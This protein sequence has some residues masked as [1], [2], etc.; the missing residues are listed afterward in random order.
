MRYNPDQ[1]KLVN[2]EQGRRVVLEQ[3]SQIERDLSNM[4]NVED[5]FNPVLVVFIPGTKHRP[6]I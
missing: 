4:R 6:H 1:S 5:A 3:G 2:R